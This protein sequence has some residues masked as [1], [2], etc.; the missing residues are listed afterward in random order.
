MRE[1]SLEGLHDFLPPAL[2]RCLVRVCG[3]P[4]SAR[5]TSGDKRSRRD[6]QRAESDKHVEIE[7]ARCGRL[8]H[9]RVGQRLTRLETAK[10]LMPLYEI[11]V[12]A[13]RRNCK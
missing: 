11:R 5:Y 3:P 7:V 9:F 8:R 6:S 13:N 1:V 4:P 10:G 2:A 12:C